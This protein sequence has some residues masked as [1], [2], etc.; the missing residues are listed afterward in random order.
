M[1]FAVRSKSNQPTKPPPTTPANAATVLQRNWRQMLR[2][3]TTPRVLKKHKLSE[4]MIRAIAFRDLIKILRDDNVVASTR[5]ALMRAHYVSIM[6]A[7]GRSYVI[8]DVNVRKFLAA[9]MIAYFP[10]DSLPFPRSEVGLRLQEMGHA[11]LN[12]F[13]GS[14]QTGRVSPNLALSI[15]N[16]M[17]HFN[18]WESVDIRRVVGRY[19]KALKLLY[20]SRAYYLDRRAGQSTTEPMVAEFTLQ[21]TKLREKAASVKISL[22][23]FDA[24]LA[25]FSNLELVT[26]GAVHVKRFTVKNGR[27]ETRAQLAYELLLDPAYT[28]AEPDS[29]PEENAMQD[30]YWNSIAKEIHAKKYEHVMLIIKDFKQELLTMMK[31]SPATE[32]LCDSI[33]DAFDV[34]L[35][36]DDMMIMGL[37]CFG[38]DMLE[39][40]LKTLLPPAAATQITATAH[41]GMP[42]IATAAVVTGVQKRINTLAAKWKA[43]A[44]DEAGDRAT[45]IAAGL[46]LLVESAKATHIE[47]G[48]HRLRVIAPTMRTNGVKFLQDKFEAR[49]ALVPSIERTRTWLRLAFSK[50]KSALSVFASGVVTLV[51]QTQ[52]SITMTSN[53]L[54]PDMMERA[55]SFSGLPNEFGPMNLEPGDYEE[56]DHTLPETFQQDIHRLRNLNAEFNAL[57]ECRMVIIVTSSQNKERA[58][59]MADQVS[60]LQFTESVGPDILEQLTPA[61][62]KFLREP[63]TDE[64]RRVLRSRLQNMLH[65]AI[66]EDGSPSIKAKTTATAAA[67]ATTTEAPK[68]FTEPRGVADE[69]ST[70]RLAKRQARFVALVTRMA[71]INR[72]IYRTHYNTILIE[73]KAQA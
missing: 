3:R 30:I 8:A 40:Y 65:Q 72:L 61:E 49:L 60:R 10:Q 26:M 38:H 7:P 28:L 36:D 37:F 34:I 16:F 63:S 51:V 55:V 33:L 35:M 56:D 4:A 58:K 14:I 43:F 68:L 29:M 20:T 41:C 46:R 17:I 15:E 64:V 45:K 47:A 5:V 59:V 24:A 13:H 57:I 23:P 9:Y 39:R 12:D 69:P 66:V 22:A 19:E 53:E 62:T 2:F 70:I 18:A 32:G 6:L 71:H 42:V 25:K 50:S 73:L 44:D 27:R 52:A 54:V 11:M 31:E 21:I 48:N 67:T 1:R